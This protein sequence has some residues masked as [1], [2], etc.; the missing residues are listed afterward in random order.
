MK[1]WH[2]LFRK[3]NMDCAITVTV[4]E[5]L[6][7]IYDDKQRTEKTLK[8]ILANDKIYTKIQNSICDV[9]CILDENDLI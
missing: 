6:S 1:K 9:I 4:C 8:E 2:T 5:L 3:E 7:K